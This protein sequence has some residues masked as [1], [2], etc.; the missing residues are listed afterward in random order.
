MS[1]RRLA[2]AKVNL[3][4]HVGDKRPD[5]YHDLLSLVVF[6]DVGDRL[7]A[8]P[9][10]KLTLNVT[11]AFP[12][13]GPADDNLV[14]KAVRALEGWAAKRGYKTKPL[15]LTLEKNLPVASGIGGGSSDAAAAL[16]MIAELWS[17]PISIGE[18]EALG[19]ELGADVPVC[20]RAAPTLVSGVGETLQPVEGLPAFA[21]VLAN[22]RV[23]VPT[24][25]VFK[26]LTVR[27]GAL[28]RPLPQF[29]TARDLAIY[30]DHT[31]ND[32][33]APAKAIAPVIMRVENALAATN[34]CLIARMSGSGA[35][36]FGL[37]ASKESAEAAAQ[38]IATAHPNWWV[39]AAEM[40]R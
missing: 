34:G 3:F 38:T 37:Y 9:A 5:G 30:L 24:A 11:G 6:A 12:N 8:S 39:K 35:T 2:P 29:A 13:T 7:S 14:M 4:L 21:L 27:T 17:L 26:A 22:P 36:C 31:M 1:A 23:E 18:L 32:L 16:L 28:A 15:E 25:S 33:A 20:L 19:L 10:D 40:K